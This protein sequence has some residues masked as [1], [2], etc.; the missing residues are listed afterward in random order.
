MAEAEGQHLDVTCVICDKE[1]TTSNKYFPNHAGETVAE[2]IKGFRW[3]CPQNS[4]CRDAKA[5]FDI[6][7]GIKRVYDGG[8]LISIYREKY[9]KKYRQQGQT[10]EQQW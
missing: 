5:M 3:C 1:F 2:Y 7:R 8:D 6:N 10:Q 9:D 4:V